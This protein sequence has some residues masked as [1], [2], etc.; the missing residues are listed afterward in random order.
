[1]PLA[2]GGDYVLKDTLGEDDRR[3]F[4]TMIQTTGNVYAS[5]TDPYQIFEGVNQRLDRLL[6]SEGYRKQP[7]ALIPDTHGR[8]IFAVFRII[9]GEPSKSAAP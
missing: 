5:H 8:Q 3:R 1:M 4:L 9:K 7:L 6:E 2:W